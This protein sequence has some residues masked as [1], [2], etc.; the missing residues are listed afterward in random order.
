MCCRYLQIYL[1]S[2]NGITYFRE[3]LSYFFIIRYL[4]KKSV[5]TV[6]LAA[7]EKSNRFI[8]LEKTEWKDEYKKKSRIHPKKLCICI[9]RTLNK[10]TYSLCSY[11]KKC[12]CMLL[13]QKF[14]SSLIGKYLFWVNVYIL[15]ITRQGMGLHIIHKMLI[16]TNTHF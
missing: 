3:Y 7:N 1:S 5:K 9:Q 6:T 10:C 2:S 11:T 14:L 15:Y 16:Y 12:K 13:Y 8:S 4:S